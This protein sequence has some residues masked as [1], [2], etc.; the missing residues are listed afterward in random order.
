MHTHSLPEGIFALRFSAGKTKFGNLSLEKVRLARVAKGTPRPMVLARSAAFGVRFTSSSSD[1]DPSC[2]YRSVRF[3]DDVLRKII[4]LEVEKAVKGVAAGI[5]KHGFRNDNL[6]GQI[7][8]L[9]EN[10]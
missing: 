9:I 2:I 5:H 8:A 10:P 4:Q 6:S 1:L 7:R 3:E